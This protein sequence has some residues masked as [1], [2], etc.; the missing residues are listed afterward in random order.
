[1]PPRIDEN[2]AI[3]AWILRKKGNCPDTTAKIM[4]VVKSTI[5]KWCKKV[6]QDKEL[7][8]KASSQLIHNNSSTIVDK[9]KKADV[10]RNWLKL[11]P[12]ECKRDFEA[13]TGMSVSHSQFSFLKKEW[14][15]KGKAALTETITDTVTLPINEKLIDENSFLRWWN[16][17]ERQGFVDRLL[18][19][20][21]NK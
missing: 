21:K 19:E 7:L 3:K 13:Q 6:E 18:K 17:G 10:V 15:E 5:H 20:L 12:Y 2:K 11:H 1:M 9:N 14:Q 8:A 16:L 4:K